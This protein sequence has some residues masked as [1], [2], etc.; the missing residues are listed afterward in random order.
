MK[1]IK[2]A[3]LVLCAVA[4]LASASPVN[5]AT[6]NTTI[7]VHGNPIDVG[8][9]GCLAGDL[10][11]AGNGVEHMTV[12][13]AGDAWVTAT[14]EG[15]ATITGSTFSGHATAWFGVEANANNF[16]TP[17]TVSA[18][19]MLADGTT[20]SIHQQGQYT[21]NAQGVITVNHVTVTCS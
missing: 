18:T 11:I 6:I 9:S 1:L 4:A 12:N 20:L 13:N 21:V 15:A 10:V 2:S 5:A 7:H 16:V 17:F 3:I 14:L 8:P 19:G